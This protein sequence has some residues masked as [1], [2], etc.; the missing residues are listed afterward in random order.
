MHVSKVSSA[1][2]VL[3]DPGQAGGNLLAARIP[4]GFPGDERLACRVPD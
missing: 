1:V 4:S 2:H 3:D